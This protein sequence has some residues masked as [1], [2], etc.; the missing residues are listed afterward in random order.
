AWIGRYRR[1]ARD[2]VRYSPTV[3]AFVRL[4]M[5]LVMLRRLTPPRH[6]ACTQTSQI[7]L[8]KEPACPHSLEIISQE[9]EAHL[10]SDL[11]EGPGQEV[12]GHDEALRAPNGCSTVCLS[13]QG[14]GLGHAVEPILTLSK[15]V[16]ILPALD[17]MSGSWA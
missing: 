2:F 9:V 8:T 4:A 12:G 16:L 17:T 6:S 14:H 13:S 11:V 10:G 5:I 3:A 15:H 7:G 1:L